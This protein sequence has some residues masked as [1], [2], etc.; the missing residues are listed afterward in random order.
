MIVCCRGTPGH[1]VANDRAVG[2]ARLR[3]PG[4]ST[5]R[6]FQSVWVLLSTVLV[7][8]LCA[9]E[10]GSRRGGLTGLASRG[11]SADCLRTG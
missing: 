7:S 8:D 6:I 4:G 11:P 3:V 1:P 9:I 5:R 10:D 2:G